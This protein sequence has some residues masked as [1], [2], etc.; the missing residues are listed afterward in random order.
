MLLPKLKVLVLDLNL[1]PHDD[2]LPRMIRS[3]WDVMEGSE[4]IDSATAAE[5]VASLRLEYFCS[6]L[7]HKVDDEQLV[8]TR[9]WRG[10]GLGIEVQVIYERN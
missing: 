5:H 2:T 3:R 10:E 7:R 4:G 1:V 8:G 6:R 9:R